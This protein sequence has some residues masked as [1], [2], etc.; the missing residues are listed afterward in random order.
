MQDS[1]RAKKTAES[2]HDAGSDKKRGAAFKPVPASI[3][4]DLFGDLLKFSKKSPAVVSFRK[5]DQLAVF[6][7][8]K[9]REERILIYK[10]FCGLSLTAHARRT[11]ETAERKKIF[12]LKNKLFISIA[13][14][15]NVRKMI[16]LR[17]GVSKRFKVISYCAD[18]T[19]KNTNEKIPARE[20][21]FCPKCKIDRNY[22]NIISM[23]HKF[24]EG[25]AALFLGQ[26]HLES[27]HFHKLIKKVPLAQIVE[28]MSFAKYKFSPKT[29]ISIELESLR[30]S[31]LKLLELS[32]KISGPT[33]Q[34]RTDGPKPLKR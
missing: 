7:A 2:A 14:D 15:P 5:F 24:S 20:W 6:L 4:L 23:Q 29:L 31:A 9:P 1:A 25:S 12:D 26:E 8:Q 11:P 30:Q 33:P 17:I 22:Y 19:E 16:N 10:M 32:V 28:E 13:N 27:L 18:C 3:K 34:P 21:K